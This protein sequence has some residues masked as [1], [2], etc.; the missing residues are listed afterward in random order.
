VKKETRSWSGTSFRPRGSVHS[1]TFSERLR[2]VDI[3]P[4]MGRTGS[5]LDNVM[6][7]G[8]VSMLKAELVSR[9]ESPTT[10]FTL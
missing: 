10:A 9:L 5:A 4:S 2:E 7:E 1:L 6:A 8:F 3:T